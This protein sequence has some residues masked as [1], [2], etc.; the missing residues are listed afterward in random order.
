MSDRRKFRTPQTARSAIVEASGEDAVASAECDIDEK[1]GRMALGSP[2]TPG[3]RTILFSSG[4]ATLHGTAPTVRSEI[5]D[6]VQDAVFDDLTVKGM[7]ASFADASETPPRSYDAAFIVTA[8]DC[9]L[10]RCSVQNVGA[11][12][13]RRWVFTDTAGHDHIGPPAFQPFLETELRDF[14]SDWW[15]ARKA[16]QSVSSSASPVC[17]R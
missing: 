17:R 7:K 15:A 13:Q 12:G 8:G 5:R 4:H 11:G 2:G 6:A 10:F 1:I 14:V 16:E 9:T 3:A